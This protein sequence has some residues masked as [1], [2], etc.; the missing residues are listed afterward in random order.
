MRICYFGIYKHD[1]SR[2]KLFISGLKANG[3]EVLECRSDKTGLSK[4]FDLI[5]KHKIIEGKY[6]AM[7][8]GYPGFQ[9][10]ILAKFLTR[11]PIIFNAFVSL[12]DSMVCDRKLVGP[13][14]F[15]ALYYWLLDKISLSFSDISIFDTNEHI[16]YISEEFNIKT[17]KLRR[18]FVGADN[19]IFYPRVIQNSTNAF[20]VIF[21]GHFIP[22]H[23]LEYIIGA[24]KILENH[25]DIQFQIIGDGQE[26]S[27]IVKLK[28]SLGL[29]NIYFEGN[30]SLFHLAEKISEADVC[31]GIFGNTNKA[32][33]VIPNKVFEYVAMNKPVIT[34]DTSAIR[35]LFSDN[36]LFLTTLSSPE[37]IAENILK[38]R[39]NKENAAT[40]AQGA[41]KKFNEQ[42]SIKQLGSELKCLIQ[43]MV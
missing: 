7:I 18:V 4:Y 32:K 26:K 1:Y 31:L 6:D 43:D 37:S 29:N 33:R 12:Y 21:C 24:A 35:E 27:R 9:S 5:R 34:A 30:T 14:S 25:R 16:K 2:N 3:V 8:V 39:S 42:V 22:L 17:N 41:Y 28:E 36:E 19:K 20:K 13:H 40:V 11:K 23:G 10:V 15:K 38:V